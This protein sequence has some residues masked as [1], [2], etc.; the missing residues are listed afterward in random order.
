VDKATRLGSSL[1]SLLGQTKNDDFENLIEYVGAEGRYVSITK[2]VIIYY[3][4]EW[5]KGVEIVDTPGF[6][7]PVVSREERTQGF[8]K[9]ADV[10]ILLLYAGR[11]FDSTDKAILFDKVQN[12]GVGK[13]LIGVNKYDLCYSQG[14]TIEEIKSNVKAEIIKACHEVGDSLISDLLNN[15]E[16]IPF[17]ANM[18]LMSRMPLNQVISNKDIKFHWD[19]ICNIFEISSQ[20][21]MLEHSLIFDLENAVKGMIEKSKQEILFKK[22]LNMILQSGINSSKK[23]EL[24]YNDKKR[25]VEYLSVPDSALDENI[26]NLNKAQ[27]RIQKKSD[28]IV[29]DMELSFN[30]KLHEAIRLL[31]DIT[32]SA[33]SDMHNIVDTEKKSNIE[34]RLKNRITKF[35]ER[36]LPRA[37]EKMKRD[38]RD[39][40]I[41]KENQFCD[42]IED[43][44]HKYL[45]DSEDLVEDS[46]RLIKWESDDVSFKKDEEEEFQEEKTEED[47]NF[48]FFDDVM[49]PFIG[50]I[51]V[52]PLVF[53]WVDEFS[54]QRNQWH[55][56]VNDYFDK[57]NFDNIVEKV[58]PMKEKYIDL[59]QTKAVNGIF[60]QLLQQLEE[61]KN[62]KA[63]KEKQLIEAKLQLSKIEN[64]RKILST[65]IQEME[66]M[67]V[68]II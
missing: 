58:Q 1:M 17:S 3:P 23:I 39:I 20:K 50:G 41:E 7:D 60:E 25:E 48:N 38:L 59:L 18:A 35:Q 30:E 44:L 14:E 47:T 33:K 52:F 9:K 45:P 12:V 21:Q 62:N 13:V 66:K 46:K 64:E 43:V 27:R 32:D 2:S 40:L 65:Q 67:K 10:V 15:L 61:I 26:D 6:N 68:D 28:R 42:D 55:N 56:Q 54:N 4:A 31:E 29:E 8:L 36:D 19:Q 57:I 51:L 11:A 37:Q 63:N 5:L 24:S 49:A 16:P 34:N 53:Y 22:P